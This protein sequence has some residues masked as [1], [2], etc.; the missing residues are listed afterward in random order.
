MQASKWL[1]FIPWTVAP[2]SKQ[3]NWYLG[4]VGTLKQ[5]KQKLQFENLHVQMYKILMI[6]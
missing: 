4:I 2:M 6:L 1:H 3:Y 5:Y